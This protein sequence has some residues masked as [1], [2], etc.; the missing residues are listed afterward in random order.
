VL[1]V[2]ASLISAVRRFSVMNKLERNNSSFIFR[3]NIG[4]ATVASCA[5]VIPFYFLMR[6]EAVE[7]YQRTDF[8]NREDLFTLSTFPVAYILASIIFWLCRNTLIGQKIPHWISIA[9][10]GSILLTV[11]ANIF[12]RT[13]GDNLPFPSKEVLLNIAFF[14]LGFSAYA[15]IFTGLVYYLFSKFKVRN[16][17]FV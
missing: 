2:S 10:L 13:Q 6:I 16:E 17:K 12:V 5:I 1:A 4:M 9:L 15:A 11:L 3:R 8:P 7:I 14:T